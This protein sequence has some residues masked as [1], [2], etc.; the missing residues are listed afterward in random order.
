MKDM[1]FE[2]YK[3]LVFLAQ[4]EDADL[5]AKAQE[6]AERLGLEF[7]YRFTG[8]GELATFMADAAKAAKPGAAKTH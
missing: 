1:V 6:I 2:H 3:K 5:T 4:F 7:E 8:Y